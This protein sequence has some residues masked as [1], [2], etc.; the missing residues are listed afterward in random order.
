MEDVASTVVEAALH[1]RCEQTVPYVPPAPLADH[2]SLWKIYA[3]HE[4]LALALEVLLATAVE[5][6]QELEIARAL[7]PATA[8]E[9]ADKCLDKLP[10]HIGRKKINDLIEDSLRGFREPSL[11]SSADPWEEESLRKAAR[12]SFYDSD[13]AGALHS[14]LK[15]IVRIF[16]R[17]P[18]NPYLDFTN[19]N[20]P[21]DKERFG[22]PDLQQFVIKHQSGTVMS[23]LRELITTSVNLHLRVA[24]AKLAYNN[25]FTYKLVYESG[26]LRKV[27]KVDPA[28]SRPR[29]QQTAQ[30]LADI[31]LLDR[32]DKAF[33][34][35]PDGIA[36]LQQFGC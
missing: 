3:F 2:L 10:P 16:A 31:G 4:L 25:D 18:E 32:R 6:L 11:I 27:Q 8:S 20:M 17:L 36:L 34:I 33:R 35:T 13:F 12:G 14:A 15:L 19:A 1:G 9:L 21:I 24:T 7:A 23:A 26:R 30:L 22:L 28:F 29:L 5:V